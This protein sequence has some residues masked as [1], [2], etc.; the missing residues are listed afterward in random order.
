MEFILTRQTDNNKKFGQM[1]QRSRMRIYQLHGGGGGGGGMRFEEIH[2]SRFDGQ[3]HA[4]LVYTEKLFV[5]GR[6]FS[7]LDLFGGGGTQVG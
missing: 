6:V 5:I 2:C 4:V 7:T 3:H 1:L